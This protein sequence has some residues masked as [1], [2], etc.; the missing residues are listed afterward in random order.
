M[1]AMCLEKRLSH[2]RSYLSLNSESN[3]TAMAVNDISLTGF[4]AREAT[5]ILRRPYSSI[6]A[7]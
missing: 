4:S 5:D 7:V 1:L 6:F 3:L 2:R